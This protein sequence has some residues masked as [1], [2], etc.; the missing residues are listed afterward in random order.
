MQRTLQSGS[1]LFHFLYV[2]R[3][4]WTL[5]L[6]PDVRRNDQKSC[7]CRCTCRRHCLL[8]VPAEAKEQT[9]FAKPFRG[10]LAEID[11][12]LAQQ[13]SNNE[14]V[15]SLCADARGRPQCRQGL[16][17]SSKFR[18]RRSRA[19]DSGRATPLNRTS[20]A[21]L[22]TGGS[23]SHMVTDP[24]KIA[25]HTA[26]K[27]QTGMEPTAGMAKEILPTLENI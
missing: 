11:G 24:K 4:S 5:G 13:R 3:A 16:P 1:E 22:S 8:C 19:W 9:S 26:G 10:N 7:H 15:K 2:R 25:P 12:K 20:A 17:S 18:P 21:Q 27:A 14:G 23:P 6:A